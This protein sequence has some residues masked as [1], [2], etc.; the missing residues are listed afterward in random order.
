MKSGVAMLAFLALAVLPTVG[1][2]E[3]SPIEKIIEMLADLETKVIGEGKD[4][5]KVYD[6]YSEFCED[7]S[8]ELGFEI[9]TGKAQ[10]AELSAVIEEE[11]STSAALESK[12]EGLA[13]DIKTDEADLDAATKVRA[14][15]NLDFKAEE[16]E[17]LE[18]LSMLERATS[19]LSKEMAKSSASML[20][21]QNAKSLT[22]ALSVMVQASVLSSADASRLTGL[23]QTG[24]E[25]A[26]REPG[27]PAAAVYEGHSDGIIGTL[28]G[29]TEKAESQLDKARK[30]ETTSLHNFEMLK[31][32]LTDAMEFAGKDMDKAKKALAESAEKKAVAE[33]DLDVTSK[34]LAEDIKAKATLHQDCMTAAEEFE[35]STKSRGEELKALA[36]AKKVIKESTSG[37][38]EQ[39]YGLNQVSLL[40]LSSSA[41]LAKFEA[42]R[43]V[44]DLARKSNSPSLAQLASRM[45]SA[46]KLGAAAGEDPFAKVK[47]LITDMIATLED[48]AEA[49]ASHKAYCDKEMSEA[50]AKKD[51][52]TA[53]SDKLSTK[54]AQ[55]K[56]ASAKLKEEVATLQGELASMAKARSEADKLRTEEKAAFDK[57][58]AEMKQGIEGVK[59]ALKVLKDY[60]AKEDKSHEASEGAASG[61]IGLLE[62]CESDFTKGLTEMTAQEES[63]AANYEAYVKED[64][65]ATVKKQQDV[66]Y[67]TQEAAALDKSVSELTTDLE[68]V[69]DE[70]TAVL[71]GL[72]KLEEM[73][74]AKAEPYA[75]RKARRESEIAG[76]KEALQ[77][78]EGQAA[79]IQKAIK[80]TLRAVR[81]H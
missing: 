29:L 53:E 28:E 6:E 7:R 51:D 15:E 80:H 2:N 64:E 72:E 78:L 13:N 52:L 36:T 42:V 76:L 50:N 38:T 21:M 59:M 8:D 3:M 20:Q 46:M 71:K 22:D 44:R 62:V 11:T 61:I 24:S 37:A 56:A 4:A 35:L 9:K 48:E 77:I 41:D 54:I 26:D 23:V 10:V 47:G 30:T 33:G 57:N 66:K 18:V 74:V 14:K 31:Q 5:Q 17:L 19:I 12:I 45:S 39:T 34:D 70:L 63:A 68:T 16:K 40:Q 49:D 27:A 81:Q 25:D 79:L 32:S 43:F 55:D 75:E 60:Y 65:I 58:S 67:K 73:C 69:T 1:A